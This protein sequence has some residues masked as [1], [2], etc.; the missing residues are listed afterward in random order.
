MTW[1]RRAGEAQR[2]GI[3]STVV[4]FREG[5]PEKVTHQVREL[6][7]VG[8]IQMEMGRGVVGIGLFQRE[9]AM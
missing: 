5:V 8:V 7:G 3:L 4:R 1:G 9:K 2:R 6:K